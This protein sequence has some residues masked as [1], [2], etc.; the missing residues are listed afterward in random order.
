MNIQQ[1]EYIL[2]VK[3][4]GNFSL[5]AEKC[6]VTQSTL[7]TMIGKFE[8][9]IGIKIF[10][11]KT[12][13][14]SITKE[15]KTII[16]QFGIISKEVDVLNEIIKS[17]KG[18]LT[19][20][21]NIGIIPTVAP[22][23]L[24]EFLND[25]AEKF[26]NISFSVSEM[27]T[28]TITDLLLKRELDVGILAIPINLTD[29]VEI[30]LYNEPFVLYDCTEEAAESFVKME[31]I[32]FNKFWLLEESHCLNTQVKSICDLDNCKNQEGINF[33]FRAGSIDSLIRFVKINKGLT[34]LPF[35]A[36]LDFTPREHKK[37][38]YFQSPVPVRAIGLVV[39]KHFVKKQLLKLLQL[40]IQGK[41]VPL[42]NSSPNELVV[43]PV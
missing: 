3:E 13:P 1:I 6:C 16:Q 26:P 36:S 9:E 39:H 31:N 28:N 8:E 17:L 29:L 43:S 10:D 35:L 7:S 33:D 22:Y 21:L 2:A 34:M 11:R 18:E 24:P 38:K 4:L 15:G 42:L 14:V 5:A 40:E 20:T 30:P 12:K 19:G 25:F 27:T 32:D 23:V 41:I 37:V